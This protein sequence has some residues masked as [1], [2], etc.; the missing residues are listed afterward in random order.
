[1]QRGRENNFVFRQVLGRA[2]KIH[3]DIAVVER[4]VDQLDVLA[5]AEVFVRLVRLL[6]RPVVVVRIKDADFGDDL[7]VLE[8]GR[9]EFQFLADVGDFIEHA[10]AAFEVVRQDGPVKFFTANARLPPAEK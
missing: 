7:G 3:E 9:E 5:Q 6:Q 2:R 1:M 8:R 10:A 4:V